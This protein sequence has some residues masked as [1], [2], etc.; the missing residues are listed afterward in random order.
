MSLT[1]QTRK[2]DKGRPTT[3]YIRGDRILDPTTVKPGDKIITVSQ[4]FRAENLA[5]V[6]DQGPTA[7][8]P[9]LKFYATW[10]QFAQ[11]GESFLDTATGFRERDP[12]EPI[13]GPEIFCVW[14]FMLGGDNEDDYHRA[15]RVPVDH[16]DEVD[17]Y[18]PEEL[19]AIMVT[20]N[21]ETRH[22]EAIARDM[23]YYREHV[24]GILHDAAERLK[25]EAMTA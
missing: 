5:V 10:L 6:V 14:D 8:N 3:G 21:G 22:L 1:F 12:G 18:T 24:Q 4:Q 7:I 25:A 2:F 11:G 13:L 16:L 20:L 23:P 9:H 19:H 17:T 15:V